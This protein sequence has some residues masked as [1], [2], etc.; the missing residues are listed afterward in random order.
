[1]IEPQ[2]A[3]RDPF[4]IQSKKTNWILRSPQKILTGEPGSMNAPKGL[5]VFD[6]AAF[7]PNQK[8]PPL[9]L[10]AA[11]GVEKSFAFIPKPNLA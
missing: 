1:M 10:F 5:R 2:S 7:W 4:R 3:Q 6:L 11:V 9:A 8:I